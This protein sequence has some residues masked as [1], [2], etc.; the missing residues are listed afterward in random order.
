M[1]V[2]MQRHHHRYVLIVLC[3][4]H[5]FSIEESM[6]FSVTELQNPPMTPVVARFFGAIILASYVK[7]MTIM[8]DQSIYGDA[9]RSEKIFS[10]SIIPAGA[11]CAAS[12]INL[13]SHSAVVLGV[14]NDTYVLSIIV[15]VGFDVTTRLLQMAWWINISILSMEGGG[16]IL[17]ILRS[18]P[19]TA[20]FLL[21]LAAM[22]W[23]Q[24]SVHIQALRL[25]HNHLRLKKVLTGA[26]NN[27]RGIPGKMCEDHLFAYS[28]LGFHV[29]PLIL[30][31]SILRKQD[32]LLSALYWVLGFGGISYAILSH[33]PLSQSDEKSVSLIYIEGNGK[34]GCKC[35]VCMRCKNRKGQDTPTSFTC[36]MKDGICLL[37]L[38]SFA[39]LSKSLRL[40]VGQLDKQK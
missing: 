40:C 37:W 11:I 33:V 18:S 16:S 4:K 9:F 23:Y 10:T 30:S 26:L 22:W 20:V 1:L 13:T 36:N 28:D 19:R 38:C 25:N 15:G 3:H 32:H 14:L 12:L 31:T 24:M 7:V 21:A 17:S 27:L 5:N 39:T 6:Q 35:K 2:P 29:L 34:V 8:F